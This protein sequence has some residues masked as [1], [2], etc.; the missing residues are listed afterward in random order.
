MLTLARLLPPCPPTRPRLR[1]FADDL[2]L[3]VIVSTWAG[4][5]LTLA[6]GRPE[7][8]YQQ[9]VYS[10]AICLVAFVI[11]N[12]ARVLVWDDPARRRRWA[13]PMLALVVVTAPVAHYSG[14]VL[15]GVLLGTGWPS[16]AD[17]PTVP[18]LS[19]IVYTLLA[20]CAVGLLILSRE[21]VERIKAERAEARTRADAIER[22]ALQAQLR[23]L[24]AQIEP[25]M[26][27]N[28]LANLQGLI[29]IDPQRASGMLDQLI[30]Y[31][32]ATLAATR[33]D[34][35]TLGAEFDAIEA[36]LGLMGVR[37]GERLR[38]RLV[39][40]DALRAARLPPLLLQPLVENAI[41][42]GL[43]PSVAGGE[44]LVTATA[45]DGMLEIVV[46]DTGQGLP[47][48]DDEDA[49]DDRDDEDDRGRRGGG[50]GGGGGVGLAT[51]RERLHAV[52]G[53]RARLDL[54]PNVPH[55]TLVRLAL[56]LERP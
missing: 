35:T 22:Q 42:H 27:F 37:M 7:E 52:Y 54:G 17:Y 14:I 43:E 15:G 2:G 32:R 39:L 18:R 55:G 19:M 51:T 3:T 24:Q 11:L 25:H 48:E 4:V 21:R 8:M 13:L 10:L 30:R 33:L 5:L 36:Y 26:L 9:I 20:I 23:L 56:P 16:L 38:P 46:A 50:G 12:G 6:N 49:R 41:V 28:T 44:L 34:S 31:L 47:G 29:A 45:R 40:P 53:A 1:R